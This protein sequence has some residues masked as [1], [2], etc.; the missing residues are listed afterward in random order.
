MNNNVNP[1]RP[2]DKGRL[3]FIAEQ[4]PSNERGPNNQPKM[5][6]RYA[7]AGRATKWL[8]NGVEEIQLELDAMPIGSNGP[9]KLFVFWDS[10][11]QN[12]QQ[13]MPAQQGYQQQPQQQGGFQQPQQTYQQ[14]H[15]GTR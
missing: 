9:V 5:K 1:N 10:Q 13:S 2:I 7:T 3:V 12:N 8:T 11:N 4:Y 14:A 15:S 6:K